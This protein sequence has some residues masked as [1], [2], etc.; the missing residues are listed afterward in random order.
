MHDRGGVQAVALDRRHF[1]KLSAG[2]IWIE[3]RSSF[4]IAFKG[5]SFQ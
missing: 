2:L 4:E 1:M 3:S 5:G